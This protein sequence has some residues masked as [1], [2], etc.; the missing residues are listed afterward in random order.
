MRK[1]PVSRSSLDTYIQIRQAWCPC[2]LEAT[3][4]KAAREWEEYMANK[5]E[6]EDGGRQQQSGEKKQVESSSAAA[7]AAEMAVQAA[8]A[9]A[10]AVKRAW[11]RAEETSK[12]AEKVRGNEHIR[13][14]I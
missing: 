6:E 5:R 13:V 1:R 12:I 3:N 11:A 9:A 10:E 7:A 2:R 4:E 14:C 8:N